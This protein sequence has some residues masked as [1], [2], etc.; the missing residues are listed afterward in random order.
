MTISYGNDSSLLNR[1]K[2]GN[3]DTYTTTWELQKKEFRVYSQ[4]IKQAYGIQVTFTLE[5][6]L[7]KYIIS[8]KYEYFLQLLMR[9]FWAPVK[10][11]MWVGMPQLKKWKK[12]I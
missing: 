10:M 7:Q 6:K 3:S 12:R 5:I 4:N 1:C 9:P 8:T 2:D 11:A